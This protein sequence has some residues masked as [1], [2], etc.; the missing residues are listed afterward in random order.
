VY[1]QHLFI[2]GSPADVES[3]SACISETAGHRLAIVD[4]VNKILTGKYRFSFN[5]NVAIAALLLFIHKG[6]YANSGITAGSIRHLL[7]KLMPRMHLRSLRL[8]D[9]ERFIV[10]EYEKVQAESNL[11]AEN[12]ILRMCMQLPEF[13]GVFF[14]ARMV[15]LEGTEVPFPPTPEDLEEHA[16]V[17]VAGKLYTFQ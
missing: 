4:A 7:H 6:T 5:D 2:P 3:R 11:I 17:D 16:E 13:G 15:T 1:R 9:A 10:V 12:I 8:Q 14:K